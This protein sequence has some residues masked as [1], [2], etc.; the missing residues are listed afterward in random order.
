MIKLDGDLCLSGGAIGADLQWGSAALLAGHGVIHWSF[1]KHKLRNVPKEQIDNIVFVTQDELDKADELLVTANDFVQRTFPTKSEY[2]NNLLRRDWLQVRDASSCYAVSEIKDGKVQGGTAWAT[3]LFVQK[4]E[5]NACPV[6][7]FCQIAESW[8]EWSGIG[9]KAIV[10]PPKPVDIY[11]GIGTR[12][13]IEIG[14][15][16]IVEAYK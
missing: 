5:F 4:H 13:I 9:W 2:V 14:S 6:Y 7:V 12:K 1:E 16:A 8:H 11:A 15:N 3:A 10:K